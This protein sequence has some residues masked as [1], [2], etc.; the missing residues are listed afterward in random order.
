MQT[1]HVDEQLLHEIV[2]MEGA[3][4]FLTRHVADD[5]KQQLFKPNKDLC[6]AFA[7][8]I[9]ECNPKYKYPRSLSSTI[10]E[11]AL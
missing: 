3:K 6:A 11:V 5:N 2:R 1:K 8:I 7:T 10:I 4:A 9:L